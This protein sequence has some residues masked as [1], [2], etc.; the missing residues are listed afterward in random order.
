MKIDVKELTMQIKLAL[1][2]MFE[3]QVSQKAQTVSLVF[4]NGQSFLLTINEK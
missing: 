2:N 3:A 4:N 1:Q